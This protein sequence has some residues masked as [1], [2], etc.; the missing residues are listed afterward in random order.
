MQGDQWT[1]KVRYS[2]IQ[3]KEGTCNLS[4]IP[5]ESRKAGV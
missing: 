5:K 3:E 4:R 1:L 2:I